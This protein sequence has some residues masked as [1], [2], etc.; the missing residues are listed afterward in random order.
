[1]IISGIDWATGDH[2][3]GTPAV[4]NLSLGGGA[5]TALD[6]AIRSLI[7]D[8]VSVAVAAGNG[9]AL[10]QPA[11]ACG[12]SPARVAE[13]ITVGA[14]DSADKK[15]SFSNYGT[16]VDLHAPSVSIV[17]AGIASDTSTATLSG[18]SM[19]SPHVAGVAALQLSVTPGASPAAVADA[20]KSASTKGVITGTGG[21]LL[22][23]STPNNHLLFTNL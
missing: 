20:I 17:S 6:N 10:G 19:A 8:G 4:A 23:G 5:S 12:V 15:A 14:S 7:A 21:G 13:A 1:M 11:D 9:N 18:T 3:P 22:G 2:K 16:C